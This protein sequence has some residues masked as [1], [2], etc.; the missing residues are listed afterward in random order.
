V[1]LLEWEIPN[2]LLGMPKELPKNKKLENP[3]LIGVSFG[4]GSRNG[5][6]Y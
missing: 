4:I 3:V 1:H 5:K 6:A 2:I